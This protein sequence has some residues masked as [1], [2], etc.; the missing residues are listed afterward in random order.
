MISV[1]VHHSVILNYLVIRYELGF[2]GKLDE[3]FLVPHPGIPM[4]M[5]TTETKELECFPIS[6]VKQ[7]A[8]VIADFDD[9]RMF[10]HLQRNLVDE[11]S[12]SLQSP[13]R[14]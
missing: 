8:W 12:C 11:V 13:S 10:W 7:C 3:D 6:A 9:P 14:I 4:R 2:L 5:A 1:R